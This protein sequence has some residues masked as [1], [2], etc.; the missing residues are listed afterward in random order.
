MSISFDQL[1]ENTTRRVANRITRRSFIG[2]AALATSAVGA[3]GLAF[4]SSYAPASNAYPC[5]VCCDSTT[6]GCTPCHGCP[7]GTCAGGSWY[8][9]TS[10]CPTG[11]Y[12]RYRDCLS[13]NC[14]TY[15]GC[16]G[17]PGC[18]YNTPYGS[19]GGHTKVWC[20]SITCLGPAPCTSGAFGC[21]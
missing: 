15:C 8:E 10:H 19:C 16:D 13:G 2:R 17:R 18:Y 1:V 9:C 7:S 20:R 3:G 5:R 11:Y 4:K 6:C 12:T 21:N 14:S